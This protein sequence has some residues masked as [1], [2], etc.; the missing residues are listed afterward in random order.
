MIIKKIKFNSSKD[1]KDFVFTTTT[2]LPNTI[3]IKLKNNDCIV[4]GRSILGVL[5]LS[6]K[7]LIDLMISNCSFDETEIYKI[8]N[9]WIVED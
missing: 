9:Q 7:G 3:Q 4:N 6:E 8:F 2:K 5:S 1:V